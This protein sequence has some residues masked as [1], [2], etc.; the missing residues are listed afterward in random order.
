M[1]GGQGEASK[2]RW[3]Q[4]GLIWFALAGDG[5]S[6]TPACHG[7]CGSAAAKD[8]ETRRSRQ[9]QWPLETSERQAAGGDTPVACL[10]G[11]IGHSA[12][13]PA[14]RKRDAF[15]CPQRPAFLSQI[16]SRSWLPLSD[17]SISQPAPPGTARA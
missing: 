14:S 16:M 11:S 13:V 3:P 10:C 4:R 8:S 15:A 12:A 17:S 7:I 1:A 6:K 9:R 2:S 5:A